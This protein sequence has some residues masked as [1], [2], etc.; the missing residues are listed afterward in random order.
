MA[1]SRLQT[2]HTAIQY[3]AAH[4]GELEFAIDNTPDGDKPY[5]YAC[6]ICK[7]GAA[8]GTV[9]PVY[10]EGDPIGAVIRAV[11]WVRRMVESDESNGEEPVGLMTHEQWQALQNTPRFQAVMR[12]METPDARG[13]IDLTEANRLAAEEHK[14]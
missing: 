12:A 9:T 2:L 7:D 10:T 11:D 8:A 5:V 6:V 14:P 4:Q 3:L 1:D 13:Y